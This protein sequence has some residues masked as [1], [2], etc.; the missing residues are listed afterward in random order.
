MGHDYWFRTDLLLEN[1]LKLFNFRSWIV[2]SMKNPNPAYCIQTWSLDKVKVSSAQINQNNECCENVANSLCF[3]TGSDTSLRTGSGF[4]CLHVRDF[5]SLANR[6]HSNST[7]FDKDESLVTHIFGTNHTKF[8]QVSRQD[9]KDFLFVGNPALIY[10]SIQVS[11]Y[12]PKYGVAPSSLPDKVT[13]KFYLELNWCRV[14]SGHYI[15]SSH[16]FPV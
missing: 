9:D 11:E 16:F 12:C 3:S 1:M 7:H 13:E 2:H 14:M 10:S 6:T 4:S 5:L 15:I 8:V